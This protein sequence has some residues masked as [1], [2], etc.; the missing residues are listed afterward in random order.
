MAIKING[1]D[2]T[3]N[4]LNSTNITE[5]T[6]N[7]TKVYPGVMT[8]GMKTNGGTR[9]T[10]NLDPI[11]VNGRQCVLIAFVD[12]VLDISGVEGSGINVFPG[13]TVDILNDGFFTGSYVLDS[14][15]NDLSGN[16]FINNFEIMVNLT[17]AYVSE[18]SAFMPNDI[19]AI[20]ITVD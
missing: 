3:T 18:L 5:E 8:M 15:M 11:T 2:V 17:N 16:L 7:G 4:R 1:T 14:G 19:Y 20:M 10:I 6:L 9:Q 12:P 13:N